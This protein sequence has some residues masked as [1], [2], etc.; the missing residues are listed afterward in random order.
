[1]LNGTALVGALLV[2]FPLAV[3]VA[4]VTMDPAPDI[5]LTWAPDE[6]DPADDELI[7][8][9]GYEQTFEYGF[10]DHDTFTPSAPPPPPPPY[11]GPASHDDNVKRTFFLVWQ[12]APGVLS[13]TVSWGDWTHENWTDVWVRNNNTTGY[14]QYAGFNPTFDDQAL[15]P[16]GIPGNQVHGSADDELITFG[17]TFELLSQ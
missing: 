2:V 1:M 9:Y 5:S 7:V 3:A 10:T 13:Y 17:K 6:A 12:G 4:D 8:P 16:M 11:S 14:V 15:G